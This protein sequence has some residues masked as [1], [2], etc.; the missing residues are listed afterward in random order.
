[1]SGEKQLDFPLNAKLR[2]SWSSFS[3]SLPFLSLSVILSL[4]RGFLDVLGHII[5]SGGVVD[6]VW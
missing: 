6:V 4:R 5:C 1:M 2:W 3:V